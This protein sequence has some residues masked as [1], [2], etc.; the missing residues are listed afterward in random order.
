MHGV[1]IHK[2]IRFGVETNLGQPPAP[3]SG[4]RTP[5]ATSG[6]LQYTCLFM[7]ISNLVIGAKTNWSNQVIP[8]FSLHL[9]SLELRFNTFFSKFKY[10]IIMKIKLNI[11]PNQARLAFGTVLDL[12]LF[13]L[14]LTRP[15]A[16]VLVC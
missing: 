11:L 16:T 12:S 15:L 5:I 10:S 3:Y 9:L 13:S 2:K 14:K 4:D 8:A 1:L 6:N 7:M